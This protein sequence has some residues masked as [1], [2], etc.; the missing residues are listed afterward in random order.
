MIEETIVERGVWSKKHGERWEDAF[1]V[2]NGH[3][4]GML[5]GQPLATQVV[6]NAP[7]FFLKGNQME[8]LPQMAIY[9]DEFRKRIQDEGYEAAIKWY[10]KQAV[11]KEGYEG[12]T[13]S[14]PIHPLLQVALHYPKEAI[15]ADS[16]FRMTDYENG[17]VM[18]QFQLESG[19]TLQ[20][21]VFVTTDHELIIE[22]TADQPFQMELG[23]VNFNHQRLQ[24]DT[25]LT[26]E[27][28]LQ[29]NTYVDGTG[30][31]THG[32]VET[33]GD[34]MLN[35]DGFVL[36]D[37]TMIVC[38]IALNKAVKQRDYSERLMYDS[39]Q[40][41]KER[42]SKVSLDLV[43]PEERL[44]SID[45]I[46]A[47]MTET[48]KIPLVLFEKLYDA[49]RYVMISCS[50]KSI[51]NLQGI[52]TG[53]FQPAWSGDYTFDTNV[54]L[55]ISSFARLGMFDEL[56]AV[57]DRIEQYTSDFEENAKAYYGSRGYMVP[58]HASTTAK[59]LHWNHEWPL[60]TWTG[61][62]AWLAHFFAEYADFTKDQTFKEE[63]ARAFY[64]GVIQFYDDF[65]V[66]DQNDKLLLRPSYSP[67][68][69]MGDNAT[70]DIAAL[71]ET[72]INAI[73]TYEEVGEAVPEHY[74]NLLAQLPDYAINESGVLKE[75][76]DW[77]KGENENHRHFSQFYP[78]FESKEILAETTPELWQAAQRAFS[79]KM[80]AWVTNE[81]SGNTSSHGRMHAAMCSIALEKAH[82]LELSIE[83]FV[84]NRAFY[85]SLVSAHYN[86]QNVFNVDS[87]GALPRIYQDALLYVKKKGWLK[88]FQA[89]P[90][91]LTKG[92]L[93]GV[94][95]P[96]AIQ[97]VDFNW[98][99]ANVS[100][101][102]VL[103]SKDNQE[104]IL[105]VGESQ[106]TVQLK[107]GQQTT[108]SCQK[109]MMEW[110]ND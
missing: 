2:G 16:F 41:H 97:V 102:L 108:I 29:T 8:R 71:K 52:W 90:Y 54:Q 61:G 57:I 96:D 32:L 78:V 31:T 9:L 49:S 48:K 20:R 35:Q 30:Y 100:F 103:L 27:G 25:E 46:I 14:D 109:G 5:Y 94:W 83:Q 68:N 44:R 10:E 73:A 6:L 66:I 26:E 12:L 36:T 22:L 63:R 67:E 72:L 43:S 51:P 86:N 89:V 55:A 42:F 101:E 84:L 7:D 92:H 106:L 59:H 15:V 13:M 98:D 19:A 21:R 70:F 88:L 69:G 82:E 58:A 64:D 105:E 110:R 3:V 17:Y 99:Q 33:D 85:D 37:T 34:L 77:S 50:G 91:W 104:L 23:V 47:E 40:R 74:L 24:Q 75:W 56:L 38:R 18:D 93:S 1:V 107:G 80:T 4:G 95:L 62:A 79:D 53:T 39:C 11:E 45:D 65:K 87:N 76:I 60:V 28:W 81:D